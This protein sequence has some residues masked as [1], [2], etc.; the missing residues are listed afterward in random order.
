M[1]SNSAFETILYIYIYLQ[2]N[3][4]TIYLTVLEIPHDLSCFK[5][6]KLTFQADFFIYKYDSVIL[7]ISE[8]F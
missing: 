1:K 5:F 7:V 2:T 6:I 8:F 3:I 4:T